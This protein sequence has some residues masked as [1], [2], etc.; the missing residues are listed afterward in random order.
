VRLL[1]DLFVAI[2]ARI[3]QHLDTQGR[4]QTDLAKALGISRQVLNK[5]IQGKKAINVEEIANI[6]SALGVEIEDL[7]KVR[8]ESQENSMVLL[9]GSIDNESTRENLR[10]ISFVMD[11]IL[12]L[13][14]I[15][16]EP[17]RADV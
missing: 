1:A 2:G 15:V 14:D 7:L 11:E 4:K 17:K 16:R 10:F 6:A 3:Q 9:M 5:I 8:H 12:E 13:E